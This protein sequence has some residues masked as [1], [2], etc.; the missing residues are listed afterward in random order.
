M[1]SASASRWRSWVMRRCD[2]LEAV[3]VLVLRELLIRLRLFDPSPPFAVPAAPCRGARVT[4]PRPSQPSP[5]LAA[6]ASTP[7]PSPRLYSCRARLGLRRRGAWPPSREA[8]SIRFLFCRYPQPPSRTPP[9]LN[10]ELQ[11]RVAYGRVRSRAWTPPGTRHSART[12]APIAICA[13]REF[14][15]IG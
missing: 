14:G 2:G 8:R 12:G 13:Y 10:A 15:S 4:P 9:A 7:T 11:P 6:R 1:W 3:C 5:R